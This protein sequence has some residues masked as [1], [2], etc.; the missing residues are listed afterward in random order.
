[1]LGDSLTGQAWFSFE[2]DEVSKEKSD[3]GAYI[4]QHNRFLKD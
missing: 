4:Q 1:M 2:S 3:I